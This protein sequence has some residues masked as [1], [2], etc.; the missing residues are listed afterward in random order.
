MALLY[1]YLDNYGILKNREF[2]FSPQYSF[3]YDRYSHILSGEMTES[4]N[5]Y[6]DYDENIE[7]LTTIIGENGSGKSTLLRFI[8]DELQH[9]RGTYPDTFQYILILMMPDENKENKD[10]ASS[11]LKVISTM[12]IELSK[13]TNLTFERIN[14]ACK[15]GQEFDKIC[16]IYYTEAFN[17][18]EYEELIWKQQRRNGCRRK[19]MMSSPWAASSQVTQR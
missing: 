19:S 6:H 13:D 17:P 14:L 10:S 4:L 3:H 7:N 9:Y 1:L 15:L 5:V 18:S 11:E 8:Y 2:T 16:V 12:D